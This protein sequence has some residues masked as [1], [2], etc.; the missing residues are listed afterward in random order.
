MSGPIERRALAVGGATAHLGAIL[1]A[2]AFVHGSAALVEGAVWV[3][4]LGVAVLTGVEVA[5]QS[6]DDRVANAHW[7]V[8]TGLLLL[9]QVA[10]VVAA[11]TASTFRISAAV[12]FL[13]VGVTLRGLAVVTLGE[14]FGT[15]PRPEDTLVQHGIY[16]HCPHPSELGLASF[17]LGL[18]LL[19]TPSW[20]LTLL[21][22]G[23]LVAILRVRREER[24]LEVRYGEAYRR[25]R[26][27]HAV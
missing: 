19:A 16:A 15:R 8:V 11:P 5:S 24:A 25:Y 23:W 1:A 14:A 3:G 18:T 9:G 4:G 10:T 20:A 6:R 13:V 17:S 22:S 7:E 21:V 27:P 26:D 12:L 2:A